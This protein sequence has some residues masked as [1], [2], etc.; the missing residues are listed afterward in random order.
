MSMAGLGFSYDYA[1]QVFGH[2]PNQWHMTLSGPDL[3]RVECSITKAEFDAGM[4][5]GWVTQDEKDA[6]CQTFSQNDGEGQ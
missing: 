5:R 2:D 3:S 1:S 6:H 4:E